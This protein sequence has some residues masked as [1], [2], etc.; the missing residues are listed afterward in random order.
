MQCVPGIV[1]Y[2][3]LNT[4]SSWDSNHLIIAFGRPFARPRWRDPSRTPEPPR[5]I[6]ESGKPTRQPQIAIGGGSEGGTVY[7]WCILVS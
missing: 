5:K 3:S 2:N 4:G 1:M 7:P 6:P